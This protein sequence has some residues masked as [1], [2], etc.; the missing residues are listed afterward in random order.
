MD[1]CD[2]MDFEFNDPRRAI[3]ESFREK[4]VATQHPIKIMELIGD[5]R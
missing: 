5:C 4:Y 2:E 3:L 1:L